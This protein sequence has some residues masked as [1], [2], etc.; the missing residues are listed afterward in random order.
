MRFVTLSLS[1][2]WCG[3]VGCASTRA[4]AVRTEVLQSSLHAMAYQLPPDK[5]MSVVRLVLVE[6]GL[7]PR[8]V[9]VNVVET[10]VS[11][12]SSSG[13]THAVSETTRFIASALELDGKTQ[14]SIVEVTGRSVSDATGG[15]TRNES[16]RAFALELEV[17]RKLDPTRAAAIEAEV[18][19]RV[20][21]EAQ[22]VE[23]A[24]EA[25]PERRRGFGLG[26]SAG[27]GLTAMVGVPFTWGLGRISL[28]AVPQLQY[29]IIYFY[30]QEA[31]YPT[32]ELG[33]QLHL[34]RRF[35]VA[36]SALIGVLPFDST[37][38]LFGLQVTPALISLGDREEHQLFLSVPLTFSYRLSAFPLPLIGYT[39]R[40]F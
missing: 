40:F 11:T 33:A 30:I 14:L 1:L 34:A 22:A 38:G 15:S 4:A 6:Q 39:Y 8:D 23:R 36:L 25:W 2:L 27:A 20:D 35:S 13:R 16:R 5:V 32:L 21:A 12:Q 9:G 3:V 26:V 28:L 18:Q 37:P 29:R 31:F 10:E 19:A 24:G 7:P 17:L